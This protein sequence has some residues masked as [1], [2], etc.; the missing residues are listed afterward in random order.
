MYCILFVWVLAATAC[1]D[2]PSPAEIAD[3]GWR[4]HELV[5][6]AGERA[7]TCAEAGPAMQRV[8]AEHRGAFVAA[9]ALD[10]DRQKL[11]EATAYL[12]EHAQRYVD[13]ETRMEALA[14]RCATD[15]A[16]VA[17]FAQMESP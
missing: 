12:E 5:V 4:A 3:R 6:A 13:L 1:K 16:V 9:L 11:A 7:K 8:F 14:E 10:R 15:P 17:V 2:A